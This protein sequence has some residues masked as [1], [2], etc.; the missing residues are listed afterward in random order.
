MYNE[1][2]VIALVKQVVKS[3]ALRINPDLTKYVNRGKMLDMHWE[4]RTTTLR[5][6]QCFIMTT[7]NIYALCSAQAHAAGIANRNE[8]TASTAPSVFIS[9]EDM[10]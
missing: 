3:P 5:G 8:R 9:L 10:E 7:P 2:H 1:W 6:I 4:Q